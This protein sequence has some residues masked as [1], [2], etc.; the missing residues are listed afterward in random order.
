[1]LAGCGSDGGSVA[2]AN[3][4]ASGSAASS[5]ANGELTGFVWTERDAGILD[6]DTGTSTFVNSGD[7]NDGARPRADG[8][9]FVTVTDDV[10]FAVD[11]FCSS[12]ERYQH[13]DRVTVHDTL[14][15]LA[16]AG[17]DITDSIYGVPQLSPDGQTLAG[18]WRNGSVCVDGELALTVWDR[19]GQ[20]LIRGLPTIGDVDWLPDGRLVF[21]IDGN[22]AVE[23]ERNTLRHDVI[24][25]LSNVPGTPVALDVSPDG[26][27]LVFEMVTDGSGWLETVD[28]RE[29]TV[30]RVG[31]DGSNLELVVDTSRPEEAAG[32]YVNA[33]V[34]S[35]EGDALMVTENWL[36]GGAITLYGSEG[37]EFPIIT[38]VDYVPI[39]NGAV[40]QVVPLPLLPAALPPPAWSAE[41]VRPVFER[42]EDGALQSARLWPLDGRSWTSVVAPAATETGSLSASDGV[43]NRGLPGRLYR[44]RDDNDVSAIERLDLATG[45]LT[46]VPG[47]PQLDLAEVD[48]LDVSDDETRF[49]V[50]ADDE[51]L[52]AVLWI[53]D[54]SGSLIRSLPLETDD[55][56][57]NP[58]G[59]PRFAP[60]SNSMFA[61]PVDDD[62][63]G[64]RAIVFDLDVAD[65]F[66]VGEG[67]YV[68]RLDWFPNGD[69]LVVDGTEL[70]RVSRTATGFGAPV[71]EASLDTRIADISVHPDGRTVAVADGRQILMLDLDTGVERRLTAWTQTAEV[72]PEFSPDGSFVTFKKL[73]SFDFGWPWV[74]ASDAANVRIGAP[75]DTVGAMRIGENSDLDWRISRSAV[76]WRG[77]Q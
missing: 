41:G 6:L 37:A 68:D 43:P 2:P 67:V 25:D 74:V 17:F 50:V 27:T 15:G 28:Y 4:D 66:G 24:A 21:E 53:F 31:I 13:V 18:Y 46:E 47:P 76:L 10:R 73:G 51:D 62:D 19:D 3:D 35:P 33:P 8:L 58:Q 42:D 54:D 20:Q 26:S 44:H 5:G 61:F 12:G 38:G 70:L 22:I 72:A 29:S 71:P 77:A 65:V 75:D 32:R 69:L 45:R 40:T 30:W 59:Q 64:Q 11:P 14:S 16:V 48:H 9:E 60:G 39:E 34:F 7:G 36:G 55:Y 49:L 52:D 1:M 63:F 23:S 56:D 57:L